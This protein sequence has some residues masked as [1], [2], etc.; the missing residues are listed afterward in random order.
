MSSTILQS[1]LQ[2]LENVSPDLASLL[3]TVSMDGLRAEAVATHVQ[4]PSLRIQ[5]SSGAKPELL[6]S[7][8]DPIREAQRWAESIT[9]QSPINAVILGAG[10]GYHLLSLIKRHHNL[11]RHIII[12]EKDPRI[13]R[14]AFSTLDLRSFVTREGVRFFAGV[15]PSLLP[16][17]LQDIRPDFIIHNCLI[18]PH[19]P[20]L[21]CFPD[22]YGQAHK[23][24]LDT[25]TYDEVNM[26]TNLENQ[27]R[28]QL[29]ILMNLPAITRG[30]ALKDCKGLMKGFPAVVSA[31]GPSLD[32]NIHWLREINDR[33]PLIIVDT[34]QRAFQK[35][36]IKPDAV[37][38]G[39]PTLLN[40]SHFEEIESLGEAFLAFH[41]ECQR[42]ITEKYIDHPFFLPLFDTRTKVLEYLF[43][44]EAEY[45]TIERAMNVGHIA[46]NLAI[47]WG[48]SPIILAGFDFA[49]PRHGGKTHAAEAAVS[50][51]MS[52]MQADGTIE[53]EGKEGKAKKESG[54]MTLVRGYYGEDVPTTVP[55]S[56]YIRAL[57]QTI[58]ENPQ[59][60]FIDAT[61]GGAYFEGAQRMPLREA[62]E[63]FLV[64]EGVKERFS[65]FRSRR[66]K[67]P[68]DRVIERMKQGRE[69]LEGSLAK[70]D[71][72]LAMI[73]EWKALLGRRNLEL[74]EAHDKWNEFENIWIEMCGQ[75]L[76][77]P[78]LGGSVQ[79]IYFLRQRTA[80]ARDSSGNAFLELVGEKY[81]KLAPPM[82]TTIIEFI[83][84]VD[85]A[86]S[87]LEVYRQKDGL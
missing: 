31:A 64:Q 11:L 36:G 1:N 86:I 18:L 59:T 70:C 2:T 38:T 20:S 51:S 62:L 73:Q 25:L 14:L 60:V 30:Y 72:L 40:F 45:G 29:N 13:L 24:L 28:N 57:E 44:A 32:Q 81:S 26:R 71:Q 80:K 15:D 63:K 65:R 56:L 83:Q 49:F 43:D 68:Y 27:G 17:E 8:Y 3:K 10:L 53:I 47:H 23:I 16:E 12:I 74:Q 87:K 22:Y 79:P 54:K 85:W 75:D 82:K 33:A 41:P 76:F 67:P 58:A 39:D 21:R 46:L 37:A 4:A 7:A 35:R 48:C 42:K 9:I 61:E 5:P 52:A 55:F 77:D 66:P 69:V 34:A 84:Y 50:R 6:H 78:F 19:Q